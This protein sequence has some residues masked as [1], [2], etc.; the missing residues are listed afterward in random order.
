M[1]GLVAVLLIHFTTGSPLLVKNGAS[2]LTIHYGQ[3]FGLYQYIWA[4]HIGIFGVILL[5]DTKITSE[6]YFRNRLVYDVVCFPEVTTYTGDAQVGVGL[7]VRESIQV[8]S[9]ESMRF[10]RPNMV[11]FGVVSSGKRTPLLGAYLPPI[12]PGA[13][14]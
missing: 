2:S 1:T 11:I 7:F 3:G 13:P 6:A 9:V 8:W 12:H 14:P 5:T 4:V 10:H